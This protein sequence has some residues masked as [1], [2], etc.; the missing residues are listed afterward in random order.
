MTITY[1][2]SLDTGDDNTFALDVTARVLE[3]QWERG[4]AQTDDAMAASA[5]AQFLLDSLGLVESDWVGVRCR[6]Q[7]TVDSTTYTLFTGN[8]TQI[9]PS[10]GW[11]VP[12]LMLTASDLLDELSAAKV[13]L[14]T[15]SQ[16]TADTIIAQALAQLPLRRTALSGRWQL[17]KSGSGE[18]A[19]NTRFA[20][21]HDHPLSN[22]QTRFGL[23][24]AGE[25]DA[26]QLIRAICEAEG[27]LFYAD[28]Q[29][30]LTFLGRNALPSRDSPQLTLQDIFLKADYGRG[31]SLVNQVT[32]MCAARETGSSDSVVWDVN[33]PLACPP[34]T[35]RSLNIRWQDSNGQVLNALDVIQPRP[36]VDYW[37]GAT[38]TVQSRVLTQQ[39]AV[40]LTGISPQG[41]TLEIRN[42]TPQS[43]Y[44]LAGATIRG[45]PIRILPPVA[46]IATD[47]ASVNR[48]GLHAITRTIPLLDNLT[49]ALSRARDIL[50]RYATPRPFVRNV[51]IDA[52][53]FPDVLALELMERVRLQLSA[54]SYDRDGFVMREQHLISQQGTRHHVTWHLLDAESV[55]VWVLGARRL[56]QDT[57]ITY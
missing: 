20:P 55:R 46:V 30:R 45:T 21:L 38:S 14:P 54:P 12:T 15:L 40:T 39:V 41:A 34:T 50:Q 29:G 5:N 2:L 10:S 37:I 22:G 42:S 11:H 25:R 8:I 4:M 57:R 9:R 27:G 43:V 17:G 35:T 19:S 47:H 18:L 28:R 24:D 26:A 1:Q 52:Q 56:R 49:T 53:R 36:M 31:E 51:T 7:A 13:S 6:V 16:Q 23:I 48:Y 32:L 3:L 44:V 33:E